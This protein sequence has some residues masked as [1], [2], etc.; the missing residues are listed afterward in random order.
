MAEWIRIWDNP[1]AARSAMR[2]GKPMLVTVAGRRLCIGL[3][4]NRFFAIADRCPH[5]G[6]S[7]SKGIINAFG[8]VV[9]P[10]HG[11]RYPLNGGPCPS[12][13]AAAESF[14]VREDADGLFIAV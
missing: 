5:N 1:E 11:Y 3:H 14:P 7:L 13:G 2:P 8:E 4:Q 9:C 10:W 6:E 12:G